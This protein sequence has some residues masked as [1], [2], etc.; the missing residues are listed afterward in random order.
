MRIARSVEMVVVAVVMLTIGA[1]E[2]PAVELVYLDGRAVEPVGDSLLSFTSESEQSLILL[3]I[4]SKEPT[5]LGSSELRSPVHVQQQNGD[6][7]LSDV[8]DGNPVIVILGPDGTLKRR[9]HISSHTSLLHQFA[10]LPDGRSVLQAK[11]SRLV[12]LDE[13]SVSTFALTEVGSRPSLITAAGGGVVHAVPDHHITLY[14][15]FG[16]IRWRIDWPWRESA[17]VTDVSVDRLG[18]IHLIVSGEEPDTFIVFTIQQDTGEI[19]RWSVPGPYA[20]FVVNVFGEV[21]P[22]STDNWVRRGN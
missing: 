22:D 13:D 9:L 2:P 7:Y 19:V 4:G 1:C 8:D 18:R 21:R 16:N 17:F 3:A 5:M 6:W 14:N 10:I 15:G 20:T 12:V 11:D